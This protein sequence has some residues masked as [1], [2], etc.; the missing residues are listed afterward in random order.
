MAAV[1][2]IVCG[3]TIFKPQQIDTLRMLSAAIILTTQILLVERPSLLLGII[4]QPFSRRSKAPCRTFTISACRTS[5]NIGATTKR[6]KKV[7]HIFGTLTPMHRVILTG[8]NYRKLYMGWRPPGWILLVLLLFRLRMWLLRYDLDCTHCC[9]DLWSDGLFG[10]NY[11][12]FG[13]R[14]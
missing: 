4:I 8:E 3:L 1:K 2:K 5:N 7:L 12:V 14:P 10:W 6:T 9:S 13:M 11:P